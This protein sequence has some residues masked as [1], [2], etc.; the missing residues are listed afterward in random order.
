MRFLFSFLPKKL[1]NLEKVIFVFEP[2]AKSRWILDFII[3]D[4]SQYLRNS[5][6]KRVSSAKELLIKTASLLPTS[7][8]ILCK[9][10]EVPYELIIRGFPPESIVCIYSHTRLSFKRL[11]SLR[12]LRKILVVNQTEKINLLLAHIPEERLEVFGMGV[13]LRYFNATPND[14]KRDIDVVVCG[15]YLDNT[16]SHYSLRKN[17]TK[18]RDT[19]NYL[20]RHGLIVALIGPSWQNLLPETDPNIKFFDID[21]K[22]T[23]SIFRRSKTYLNYSLYE[24]GPVS[25]LEAY[26]CGCTV[27]STPYGWALDLFYKCDSIYLLPPDP[28]SATVCDV[29]QSQARAFS[30]PNQLSL[31]SRYRMLHGYTFEHLACQLETMIY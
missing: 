14:N 19:I 1:A 13:D 7:Y 29:I 23:P 10:Q 12:E 8:I 2:H 5:T 18:L 24:G 11:A 25:L 28:S 9:N 3:D 27:I 21:H 22:L 16:L 15:R 17:Y 30:P 4:I 20:S 31:A 6:V 26:A